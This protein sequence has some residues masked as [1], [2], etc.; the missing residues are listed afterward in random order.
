MLSLRNPRQVES[1]KLDVHEAYTLWRSST[2]RNITIDHMNYLR[3]FIHDRDFLLFLTRIIEELKKECHS[4]EKLLQ[5]YS[6]I[7]SEPAVEKYNA[8]GNSEILRDQDAAEVMYRFL[9]LDVNLN[10]LSLK[11]TPTDDGVWSLMVDLTKSAINRVDRT[12]EY[13]KLKNWLYE[14]PLYPYVAPNTNEKV[15]TNEIALLWDHLIFRYHNLRQ[16][17]VFSTLASDPDLMIILKKGVDILQND[18]GAL[19]DKLVYYGVALP[20]HYTNITASIENKTVIDDKYML[21]AVMRGMRDAI[22]LHASAIQEVI[23]NDKLRKFFIDLTGDEID[24]LSMF[25]KY[26]KL[27]NWVYATPVYKGGT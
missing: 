23:V 9:R 18:I 3:N 7:G 19:E 22:A 2:D 25:T 16:T 14:P 17:Q 4:L 12:I 5:K 27:K 24:F 6:I 20:R 8:A 13:M 21:N 11:Y 1:I 26:G 15:A 10:A